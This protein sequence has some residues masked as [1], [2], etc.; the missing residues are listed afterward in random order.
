MCGTHT[1]MRA[2]L[3]PELDLLWSRKLFRDARKRAED[4][5]VFLELGSL[6]KL[7]NH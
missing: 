3:D 1:S 5:R 4:G 7:R 6:L 2:V